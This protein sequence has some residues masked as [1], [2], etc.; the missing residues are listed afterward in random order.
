MNLSKNLNFNIKEMKINLEFG[1]VYYNKKDN[2]IRRDINFIKRAFNYNKDFFELNKNPKLKIILVYSRKELDK[3][4]GMKTLNYVSA[5]AKRSKIIIFS[6]DIFDKETCWKKKEFYSTLVHEINHIFFTYLTKQ[7][8]EPIWLSEGLATYLQ[9][10][11]RKPKKKK[12]ISY[13]MLNKKFNY[14]NPQ[15]NMYHQ[16]VYY[17][18]KEY[19]REKFIQFLKGCKKI[20]NI[21]ENFENVYNKSV[22]SLIRDAN[23]PQFR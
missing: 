23:K 15:Y 13:D 17:L 5:F 16:F 7:F 1:E 8:Y 2:S 18:I 10:N 3:L 4:F 9:H 12:R 20:K 11:E 14:K 21:N 19:G 22:I 6:W